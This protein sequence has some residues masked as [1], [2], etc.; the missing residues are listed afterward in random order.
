MANLGVVLSDILTKQ[1]YIASQV[2]RVLTSR[3]EL[4]KIRRK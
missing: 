3:H 2:W 4:Q 1:R